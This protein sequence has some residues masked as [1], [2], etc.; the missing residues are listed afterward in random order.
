MR[1]ISLVLGSILTI[2]FILKLS[3]GSKK[4]GVMF[5]GL[6]DGEYPLKGIYGVG[7]SWSESNMFALKGKQREKMVGQAKLLYDPRYAEYYANVIWAQM[8][9]FIHLGLTVCTLFAGL[10]NSAIF[11]VFGI[12]VAVVFGYYFLNRMTD[13]LNDRQLACTE[14]LPEIVS[15]MA[16]LINSGMMLRDAWRKIAES[17][18]GVAYEL[19]LSSCSDMANGMAEVDAIHK[20]GRMSN[21]PEIRKFTSALAQSLE[22]GGGELAD[23][24]ARQTMEMWT[25]K[26][27]L[28]LQKGEKAASKLLAPTSIIFVGIIIVVLAGALGML[29]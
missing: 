3:V 19:M 13:L 5:E 8:I 11:L 14:E 1:M 6:D 10:A 9:S 20:F 23:F 18:Q 27:Q 28:M 7:F 29:I 12:V 24:L 21:S 26:K 17:K 22:R 16:L 2:L 4:Y 25:L 15:T